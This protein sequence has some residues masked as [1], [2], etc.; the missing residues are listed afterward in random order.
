MCWLILTKRRNWLTGTCLPTIFL[1]LFRKRPVEARHQIA[2]VFAQLAGVALGF[3]SAQDQGVIE[4]MSFNA[5]DCD[6]RIHGEL[7]REVGLAEGLDLFVRSRFLRAKIICGKTANDETFLAILFIERFE[8]RILGRETA[9]YS[10]SEAGVRR[11]ALQGHQGRGL[12][13][14]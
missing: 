1:S 11:Y 4:R 10:A 8:R 5:G 12:S 9:L 3:R 14:S 2:K 6:L 13:C 7:H